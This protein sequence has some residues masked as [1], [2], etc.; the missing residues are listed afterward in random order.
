MVQGGAVRHARSR[1]EHCAQDNEAGA[2]IRLAVCGCPA[3]CV[4]VPPGTHML[5]APYLD[6]ERMESY[7]MA[8]YLLN[9]PSQRNGGAG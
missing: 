5:H 2:D 8:V 3:Q 9:M 6:G 1:W 4:P 7:D